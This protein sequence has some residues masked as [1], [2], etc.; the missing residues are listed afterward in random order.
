MRFQF[1]FVSNRENLFIPQGA[2]F[3]YRLVRAIALDTSTEETL[4]I[5]AHIY[6]YIHTYKCLFHPIN[7]WLFNK[8]VLEELYG[9]TIF[10]NLNLS[11]LHC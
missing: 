3:S 2:N 9:T 10:F 4:Y 6:I 1:L 5:H 8:E 7:E 11:G